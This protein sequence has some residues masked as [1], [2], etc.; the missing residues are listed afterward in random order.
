MT[1]ME[2]LRADYLAARKN[3]D[4]NG[5]AIA[6]YSSLVGE[7]AMVGKNNGN[8]E[9]TD[10]EAL[11]VVKKFLDNAKETHSHVSKAA[12]E[13]NAPNMGDAIYNTLVEIGILEKYMPEQLTE[14]KLRLLI[15][16]FIEATEGANMGHV[17]K[18]LQ[19]NY[20]G[21]YDGKLASKLAKE[22]L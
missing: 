10:E 17:M 18:H 21:Q 7:A 4:G 13:T 22:L 2:K 3:R 11:R 8:R 9:T 15:T 16:L 1:L 6:L 19:T 12:L 5:V 14:E 20:G